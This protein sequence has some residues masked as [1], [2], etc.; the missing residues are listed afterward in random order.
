MAM[1]FMR[2]VGQMER[3]PNG[4]GV[5]WVSEYRMTAICLPLGLHW[6]ASV[7]RAAWHFLRM[8]HTPS[9]LDRAVENGWKRGF[10]AG[11]EAGLWQGREESRRSR[12]DIENDA[13]NDF[14]QRLLSRTSA[15]ES[16]EQ[17]H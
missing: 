12:Q 16:S 7:A 15:D 3:I 2:E 17:T 4:Y 14:I 11:K 5:A 10:E 13:I 8:A 9:L 1:K 6:L